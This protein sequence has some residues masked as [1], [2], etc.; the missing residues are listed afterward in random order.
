MTFGMDTVVARGRNLSVNGMAV[1]EGQ[2]YLHNG[3]RGGMLRPPL[4]PTL[5]FWVP[6]PS[7][8]LSPCRAELAVV[9]AGISV[10]WPGDRV[11]V[12][13]GLGVRVTS[14]GHQAVTVT[15]DAELWGST[16]G[17]CGPYNDDP[18]G[19]CHHTSDVPAIP[20]LG[21][22]G[23]HSAGVAVQGVLCPL[24]CPSAPCASR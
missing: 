10:A 3:E 7:L 1:L 17:L 21:E 6:I 2:P 13:S 18:T 19:E 20:A 4:P 16:R 11:A 22:S 8:S 24:A 5:R 23:R 15:V 9:P 12:A 14:D